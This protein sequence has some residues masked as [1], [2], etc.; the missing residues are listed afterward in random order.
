MLN[1]CPSH[2]NLPI[3]TTEISRNGSHSQN[4]NRE[5]GK[6]SLYQVALA[7]VWRPT[8]TGIVNLAPIWRPN[9]HE[10]F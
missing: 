9:R 4:L 7:P 5:L 3:M 8:L 2:S 6:L 10:Y 1:I